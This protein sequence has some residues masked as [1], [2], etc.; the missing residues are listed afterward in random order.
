MWWFYIF[1][2]LAVVL[3]LWDKLNNPIINEELKRLREL[4]KQ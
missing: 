2:A 3:F 1:A 4:D